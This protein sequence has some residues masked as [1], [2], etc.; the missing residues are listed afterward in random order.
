MKSNFEDVIDFHLAYGQEIRTFPEFPSDETLDLRLTLIQEEFDEV[1]EAI[2]KRDIVN[3]AKE[4]A[5]L[6]YVVYGF[7]VTAGIDLDVVFKE[8]QRSNMSK[9]GEDGKP[10]YREDGKVLKGP[11]YSPA[12]IEGLINARLAQREEDHS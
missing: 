6:L 3:L 9:L 7:G 8:V 12:D 1:K 4:L 10:I 11:N 2:A 5:D